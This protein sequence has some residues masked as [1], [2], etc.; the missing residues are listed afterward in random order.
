MMWMR[1]TKPFLTLD[2][3]SNKYDN[4]IDLFVN[5]DFEIEALELIFSTSA[6]DIEKSKSS[7]HN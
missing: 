3:L 1:T 7:D 2:V 6:D 5:C 4:W